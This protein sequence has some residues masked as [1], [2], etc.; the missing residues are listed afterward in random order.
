MTLTGSDAL[1]ALD[2]G[3]LGAEGEPTPVL[4]AAQRQIREYFDGSRKTFDIPIRLTGGTEF[5]QM[6]WLALAEIPYGQTI[7]YGRLAEKL[8][9]PKS[10]RAVGQA[11][12]RNPVGL[13]LPCHRVI[14]TDGSLTGFGGGLPMKKALLEFEKTGVLPEA[15]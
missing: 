1:E 12:S 3:D 4:L 6:V 15:D 9:R 7:T 13:V 8:N 11:C 14:G 10:F 5:L 2:F